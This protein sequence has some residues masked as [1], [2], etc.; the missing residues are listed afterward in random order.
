VLVGK[1]FLQDAVRDR[2]SA[3]GAFVHAARTQVCPADER[4]LYGSYFL[5]LQEQIKDIIIII[6]SG[7]NN[8]DVRHSSFG[9]LTASASSETMRSFVFPLTLIDVLQ[10][11]PREDYG[12][13][14]PPQ[15][16][17]ML[18][19]TSREMRRAVENTA[20][21]VQRKTEVKFR[22]GK[23]LL[24]AVHGLSWCS[25]QVLFLHRCALGE[26]GGLQLATALPMFEKLV[27]L[28][29]SKNRLG[30]HGARAVADAL[31]FNTM[32]TEL[33]IGQ[34]HLE[35]DGG[36][37]VAEL[38]LV[39]PALTSL[40]IRSNGLKDGVW[41]LAEALRINNKLTD[42]NLQDNLVEDEAGCALVEA[43]RENTALVTLNL[44]FNFLDNLTGTA[45]T[46]T[47]RVNTSLTCLEFGS[48]HL[49]AGT[50]RA[51]SEALLV[52]TT[53]QW[54]CLDGNPI[55]FEAVQMLERAAAERER[56]FTPHAERFLY[57][58]LPDYP[59]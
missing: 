21:L 58:N 38:L 37:A 26:P 45:L 17:L 12:L 3:F 13:I 50:G 8:P 41:A 44:T 46:D 16:T 5:F 55:G 2:R 36:Y 53:L 6:S 35:S 59:T 32:L 40:I 10:T 18:R 39:H 15:R 9:Y 27:T 24:E 42:L 48:N 14:M 54:L 22:D 34:N 43:L 56:R 1:P 19:R 52:N 23:G 28:T 30:A 49:G 20:T 29:V 33:D 57:L 25:V 7:H 4:I 51:I 31:R 47:L 11:L